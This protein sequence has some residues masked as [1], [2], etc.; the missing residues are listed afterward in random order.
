MKLDPVLLISSV[1][2]CCAS[3]AFVGCDAGS[4]S[5]RA[6]APEA[7]PPVAVEASDEKKAEPESAKAVV[8]AKAVVSEKEP[9]KAESKC[10]QGDHRFRVEAISKPIKKGTKTEVTLKF[11]PGEGYKINTEFPWKLTA[12]ANEAMN[13]VETV[14]PKASIVLAEAAATI[15]VALE[16]PKPG[17]FPL[18]ALAGLSVCNEERCEIIRGQCVSVDVTVQ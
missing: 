13:L 10:I 18:Q 5:N 8:A 4:P 2:I 1:A 15:P 16:A 3:F 7:T 6:A 17:K 14:V 9:A 12:R 11:L